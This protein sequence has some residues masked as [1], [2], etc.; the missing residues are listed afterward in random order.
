M[1]ENEQGCPINDPQ[2][3]SPNYISWTSSE[4]RKHLKRVHHK[5]DEWLAEHG[6]LKSLPILVDF[7]AYKLIQ[8]DYNARYK[9]WAESRDTYGMPQK[10]A[11]LSKAEIA[12]MII[13]EYYVDKKKKEDG[14]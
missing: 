10:Y 8:Y 13:K 11:V 7:E 12:S 2:C 9:K 4:S 3:P 5:S 14:F 6:W 1:P